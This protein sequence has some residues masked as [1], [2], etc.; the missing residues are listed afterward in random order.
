MHKGMQVLDCHIHYALPTPAQSLIDVMDATGIDVANLVIVPNRQRVSSVPDALMAKAQFPQRFYV[1]ASLDVSAYFRAAKQ[2]GKAMKKY[3]AQMLRCGCDGIKIIEGKPNMRK[4]L[5]VPDF[6]DPVWDPFFA[7]AEAEQVPIL[8]HVNDPETFWHPEDAPSWA[9]KQG[10]LYDDSFI[11]N[12]AQ[13]RQILNLLE[14]HP[15]LKIIFAHF[16]FMSAQLPRLS[17]IMDRFP[18]IMVDTTPG[19]EL[20]ENLS[21]NP[22][23]AK[24]FFAKYGDRVVYGTDIG[25]RSVLPGTNPKL[26]V[27]ECTHRAQLAQAYLTESEPIPVKADGDFLVGTEDFALQGL[28]LSEEAAQK[29]LADNFRRFVSQVPAPVVPKQVLKY[30]RTQKVLIRMMSMFDRNIKPDMT[31]VNEIAAFFRT[32]T[33]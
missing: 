23:G 22:E 7:W 9:K 20:Y 19:I 4:E 31:C 1:F 26:N 13:Y 14:R 33:Q 8:W 15:K 27:A 5:P 12:E 3:A 18:N 30:L 28:G 11:N 16:F 2:L 24:A 25:A 10:W 6:D 32:V 21:A 17:Q 29:V